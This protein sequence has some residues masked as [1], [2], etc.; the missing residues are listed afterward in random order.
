MVQANAI[1][2][3]AAL[4]E[5]PELKELAMKYANGEITLAELPAADFPVRNGR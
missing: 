1:V 2:G 3:L 5:S 4:P